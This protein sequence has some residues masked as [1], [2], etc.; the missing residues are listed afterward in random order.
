M[1][2]IEGVHGAMRKIGE[3]GSFDVEVNSPKGSLFPLGSIFLRAREG[4]PATPTE[5]TIYVRITTPKGDK[6]LVQ[7]D[8]DGVLVEHQYEGLT[9][10]EEATCAGYRYT[11]ESADD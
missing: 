11:Y 1:E 6:L 4:R 5:K 8:E 7:V 9:M 3:I 2:T 10:W